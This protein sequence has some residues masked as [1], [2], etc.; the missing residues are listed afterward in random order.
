MRGGRLL[1]SVIASYLLHRFRKVVRVHCPFR[2]QRGLHVRARVISKPKDH[3][4]EYTQ[5]ECDVPVFKPGIRDSK[6]DERG[7]CHSV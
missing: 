6:E 5:P 4:M 2:N 3:E 7:S 1:A